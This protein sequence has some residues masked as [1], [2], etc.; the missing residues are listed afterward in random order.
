MDIAKLIG[1][2]AN[3]DFLVDSEF[4]VGHFVH[5]LYTSQMSEPTCGL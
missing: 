2:T 1:A 4:M 5:F 3:D